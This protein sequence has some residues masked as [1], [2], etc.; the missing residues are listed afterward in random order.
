MRESCS[1]EVREFNCSAE[2]TIVSGL[3]CDDKTK[4]CLIYV[5]VFV[6]VQEMIHAAL[7]QS[8]RTA[9]DL[10]RRRNGGSDFSTD[11]NC[12]ASCIV[13]LRSCATTG[14]CEIV[15]G[16]VS[17]NYDFGRFDPANDGARSR[18]FRF[19]HAGAKIKMPSCRFD[20]GDPI[21]WSLRTE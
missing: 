2:L 16:I 12:M 13:G 10:K 6:F 17:V 11:S 15:S 14:D 18:P 8:K 5:I 20:S 3:Q 4:I 19:L 9:M 1:T 7:R 21:T